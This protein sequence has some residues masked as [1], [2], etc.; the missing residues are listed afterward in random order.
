MQ[1]ICVTHFA[2]GLRRRCVGPK[3]VGSR[4]LWSRGLRPGQCGGISRL[5]GRRPRQFRHLQGYATPGYLARADRTRCMGG[6]ASSVVLALGDGVGRAHRERRGNPADEAVETAEAEP[7]VDHR[8]SHRPAA[9]VGIAETCTCTPSTPTVSGI[10]MNWPR[11][12]GPADWTSSCRPS[13]TPTPPIG[14][15][16]LPTG[17]L[18][19]IPGEEVT[20]RHGH[21]LAVGLAPQG[22]VDWRYGRSDG[23]FPRFAAE[24]P[25]RVAWWSPPIRPCQCRGRRGSSASITSTRSRY[26]TAGGTSMMNCRFAFGSGYYGRIG[27]SRPSAAAT[28]TASTSRS[29]RHRLSCTRMAL[30][31]RNCRRAALRPFV[32]RSMCDVA[33][34]LTASTDDGVAGPG[35]T[36]RVAPGASVTVTAVISGPRARPSP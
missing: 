4:H 10:P 3:R 26:G 31:P 1:R 33:L 36:L 2:F 16:G 22:W 8:R 35:Q 19:V 20:T 9:R 28:R 23:V 11:P 24:V 30:G 34:E 12:R 25:K 14:L 13:T 17:G 21:W 18:L 27:A 7:A 5:V 29:A 32:P 6:R 15:A